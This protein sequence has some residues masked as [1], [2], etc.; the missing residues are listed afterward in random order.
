MSSLWKSF[1]DE[2]LA[3]RLQQEENLK[4]LAKAHR[5][6]KPTKFVTPGSPKRSRKKQK[7]KETSGLANGGTPEQARGENIVVGGGMRILGELGVVGGAEMGVYPPPVQRMDVPDLAKIMEEEEKMRK[8]R[9]GGIVVS[10]S[11]RCF[12]QNHGCGDVSTV[13]PLY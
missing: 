8:K 7:E 6:K 4:K 5:D 3:R 12:L 9:E 1:I 13:E 11:L 2:E 10:A